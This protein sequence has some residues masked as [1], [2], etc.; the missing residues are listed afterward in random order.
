MYQNL[1]NNNNN[2]KTQQNLKAQN[3]NQTKFKNHWDSD[4]AWRIKWMCQ[5]NVFF[6]KNNFLEQFFYYLNI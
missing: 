6:C 4:T 3:N 1:L 2:K 5:N